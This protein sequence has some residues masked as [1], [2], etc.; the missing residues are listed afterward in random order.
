MFSVSET[1]IYQTIHSY[2]KIYPK[3][4][5]LIKFDV[6]VVVRESGWETDVEVLGGK[7]KTSTPIEHFDSIRRT[8]TKISDL[9]LCNDFDWFITYTFANNRSD[10]KRIKS[11]MHKHLENQKLRKTS[12]SYILVPE[13]HKDGKSLHF[14]GLFKDYPA[15]MTPTNIRKNG[16]LIY[17]VN[18]YRLGF[19]TA[20]K[21]ADK[22]KTANYLRKYITKDMPVLSGQK[23]Y[24]CSRN[25]IRPTK[26][27]NPTLSDLSY[28]NFTP[29]FHRKNLTVLQSNAIV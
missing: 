22:D 14:H 19:T 13:F 25:L 21:I 29:L 26:I 4:T 7:P 11:Q 1:E 9:I 5:R 17:N 8:K 12:F 16:K 24:W 10:I 2:A 18:S 3:F 23:R 28:Q 6:P 27:Y 15:K 20:S